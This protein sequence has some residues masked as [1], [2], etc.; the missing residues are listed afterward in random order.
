MINVDIAAHRVVIVATVESQQLKRA[1]ATYSK[2][3]DA[4]VDALQGDETDGMRLHAVVIE[5][6]DQVVLDR[7]PPGRHDF[8]EPEPE[9]L[10]AEE[11]GPNDEGEGTESP[12]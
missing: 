9:E 3:A 5:I 1:G 12:N 4:I 6:D 11:R 8:T 7:H 2:V 10:E